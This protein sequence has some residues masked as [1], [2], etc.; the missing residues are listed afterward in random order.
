MSKIFVTGAAGCVGSSLVK[1]LAQQGH[2][3][4]ILIKPNTWHPY[5]DGLKLKVFYGDIRRKSDVLKAMKGCEYAYQVAG[6]VS[7]NR[8]DFHDMYTTHVHGVRKVLEAAMEL[9]L[10]KVVVTGSTAGIGIPKDPRRPLREEDAFDFRK[11]KKVMYMYS[12]WKT[13]MLVRYFARKGL[14]V[15]SISPTTIYGQGDISMHIGKVVKKI[16]EGKLKK[17]PPGGNAVVSV[18]DTIDAHLLAMAK[19]KSGEDY[20]IANEFIPY[21]RMFNRIA[22]LL[23]VPGITKKYPK[24]ILEPMK[25]VLTVLE[26]VMFVFGKKPILSAHSMNFSFKFRYFDSAKIRRELGWQPKVDFDLAMA[27]AIE[28]YNDQDLL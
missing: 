7:Y 24:I 9:G 8:L 20:I 15:C 2:Q 1:K 25:V 12:K 23:G 18:D 14:N 19:G 11:Y 21:I 5:L 26:R 22:K 28:F 10:K 27:K 13:R 17:A 16:K 4:H 6:V 3:I